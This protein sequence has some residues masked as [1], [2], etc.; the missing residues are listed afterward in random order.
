M[1]GEDAEW[2]SE[3]EGLESESDENGGELYGESEDIKEGDE[4]EWEEKYEGDAEE[5]GGDEGEL[6][7]EDEDDTEGGDNVEEG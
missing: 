3:E 5:L 2:R 1:E 7:D 4:E 6:K